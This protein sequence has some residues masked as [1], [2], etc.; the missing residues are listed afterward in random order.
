MGDCKLAQ[1]RPLRK[2]IEKLFKNIKSAPQILVEPILFYPAESLCKF[3]SL[4]ERV[5]SI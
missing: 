3:C 4:R 2:P 1:T 5:L